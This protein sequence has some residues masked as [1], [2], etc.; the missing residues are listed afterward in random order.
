MKAEEF[1][2]NCAEDVP[3]SGI[4]KHRHTFSRYETLK[5]ME[6]YANDEA[7]D[8]VFDYAKYLVERIN[9]PILPSMPVGM[10]FNKWLRSKQKYTVEK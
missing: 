6:Q 9:N 8:C 5:L 7:M 10:W 4:F 3:A 2:E 1:L